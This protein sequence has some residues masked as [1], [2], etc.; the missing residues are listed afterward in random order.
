MNKHT[1]GPWNSRRQYLGG[2]GKFTP[3]VSQGD[4]AKVLCFMNLS[5]AYNGYYEQDQAEADAK[6]IAAAPDLLAALEGIL[7]FIPKSSVSD[8]GASKY[9]AAVV[10]ADA[11]R[12]A[13]SKARGT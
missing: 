5:G 1:Q 3:Y 13:I 10:A 8:G 9:S 12:A 11:I 2:E 4:S 7:P 6:L